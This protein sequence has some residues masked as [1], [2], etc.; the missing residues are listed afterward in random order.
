[1]VEQRDR[2]Q[3]TAGGADPEGA[4][5][6]DV[7]ATAVL[8]GDQLVDGGVDGGVLTADAGAGEEPAREV[9]GRVHRER[10]EHGG[11]GV[12]AERDEEQL[13][14]AEPVRQ[15]PEEEGPDAGAGHV[16]GSREADVEARQPQAGVLGLQCLRHRPDDRDLEPVEDP[17]GAQ[18]DHHEP[19]ESGPRQAVHP[20]RDVGGDPAGLHT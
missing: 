3:R 12:D 10:R 13:L 1:M 20:G 18:P 17:D 4:V 6:R 8:L 14:A 19:V 2:E 7:H 15:L 5:D 9:P 16:D 11:H